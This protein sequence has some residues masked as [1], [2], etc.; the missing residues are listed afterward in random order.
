MHSITSAQPVI[1]TSDHEIA[2]VITG[3]HRF[4][5]KSVSNRFVHRLTSVI[6]YLDL[7]IHC[8]NIVNPEKLFFDQKRVADVMYD[9]TG[10]YFDHLS[11]CTSGVELTTCAMCL[12]ESELRGT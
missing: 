10:F 9:C 7:F 8:G 2:C 5:G 11:F 6:D 12:Q 3:L 4:L 1:G